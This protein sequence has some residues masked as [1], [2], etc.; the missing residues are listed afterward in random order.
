VADRNVVVNDRRV[1]VA[2]DVDR[3]MV[4][5]V[6]ALADADVATS[7]RTIVP[8]QMDASFP[9]TTSPMTI[10]SS[11]TQASGCTVG[12]FPRYSLSIDASPVLTPVET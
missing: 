1:G 11:A 9:T 12:S 4:L 10:A 3:A 5:D 2:R 7:P 6:R 8:N